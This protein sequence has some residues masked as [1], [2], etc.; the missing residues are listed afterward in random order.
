MV[1]YKGLMENLTNVL[2]R[3]K[4]LRVHVNMKRCILEVNTEGLGW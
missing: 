3:G 4:A 2:E 1:G